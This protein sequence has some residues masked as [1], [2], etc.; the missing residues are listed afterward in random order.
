[1]GH[2]WRAL[3]AIPTVSLLLEFTVEQT[4]AGTEEALS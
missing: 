3:M 4:A 1:M 2:M